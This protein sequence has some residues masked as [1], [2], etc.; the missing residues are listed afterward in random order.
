MDAP[1]IAS[2]VFDARERGASKRPVGCSRQGVAARARGRAIGRGRL[3]TAEVGR[4]A[5]EL[6]P[7][8]PIASLPRVTGS[9][10]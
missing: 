5:A 7:V 1:P 10:G 8:R 6:V 4:G 2:G 9:I 3:S